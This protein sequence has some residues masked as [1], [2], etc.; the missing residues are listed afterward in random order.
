MDYLALQLPGGK[1]IEPPDGIQSGGINELATILANALTIMLTIAV[2]VTLI[3]LIL[4]GMQWIS[5]GGDKQKVAAA[6]SR[7]TW[8]IIGLIVALGAFFIINAIGYLVQTDLLN[9]GA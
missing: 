1:A 5:S 7:L 6:R 2:I 4:G 8:A 9:V 3:Y